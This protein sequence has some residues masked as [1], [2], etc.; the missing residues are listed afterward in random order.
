MV[1]ENSDHIFG[2]VFVAHNIDFIALKSELE[3][4]K[5]TEY[6]GLAHRI[7]KANTLNVVEC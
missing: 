3:I 4:K 1:L 2:V 7:S 6:I 5:G